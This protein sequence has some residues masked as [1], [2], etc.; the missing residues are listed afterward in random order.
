[1]TLTQ[2]ANLPQYKDL[3]EAELI[4]ARDRILFGNFEERVDDIVTSFEEDYDITDIAANDRLSL[5]SLAKVFLLLEKV[6][7]ALQGQISEE[8]TDWAAFEKMNRAA[9][10]LRDD[11]SQL[12]RDLNVTRKA[13]AGYGDTSVVE[14]ISD[15]KERAKHFLADR[16]CEIYC[17]KCKML[18]AKVWFLF[19]QEDNEISLVCG[20]DSCKNRFTFNSKDFVNNKNIDAGPPIGAK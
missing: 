15:L 14:F 7:K 6:D 2:I 18:L 16:L 20:R 5:E 9:A 17:P 3:S 10:Q 12:Q 1:M 4:K 8:N 11:V 19:P 13:R